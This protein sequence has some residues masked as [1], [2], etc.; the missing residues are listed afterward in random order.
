MGKAEPEKKVGLT[1]TG[2]DVFREGLV[3]MHLAGGAP[4]VEGRFVGQKETAHIKRA[5]IDKFG[6]AWIAH[7]AAENN[8]H[9]R[10]QLRDMKRRHRRFGAVLQKGG[11]HAL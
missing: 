5:Q 10:V 9:R 6:A 1:Q 7:P 2:D 3:D 4:G 11:N 8:I